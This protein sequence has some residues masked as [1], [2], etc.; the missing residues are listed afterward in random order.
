MARLSVATYNVNSV[1]SRIPS[2]TRWLNDN[3]VDVL[4]LQ[5]IRCT[6][7]EEIPTRWAM[8]RHDQWVSP[9]GLE[10]RVKSTTS[11][12]ASEASGST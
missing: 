10:C 9:A 6:W 7:E 12:I 11:S 4:C 1:R 5:E 8:L 3:R 2:L